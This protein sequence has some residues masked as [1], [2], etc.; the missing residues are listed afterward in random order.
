M[1]QISCVCC[2][3]RAD[4]AE[5]K[6]HLCKSACLVKARPKRK[7]SKRPPVFVLNHGPWKAWRFDIHGSA[8]KASFQNGKM[9]ADVRLTGFGAEPALVG[10]VAFSSSGDHVSG[11]AISLRQA[12]L[13]FRSGFPSTPVVS[14][15]AAGVVALEP[16]T[17]YLTGT[18][19]RPMR[20]FACN[21]PLTE[22]AIHAA[23]SAETAS[24]FSPDEN[25]F[26]LLVPAELREGVE[27]A[28]WS[29]I[30]AEPNPAAPSA[31]ENP[32]APGSGV[33]P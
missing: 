19:Q 32:P 22:K 4:I 27:L 29:E 21:P 1:S 26:S 18:L 3:L 20:V 24:G 30:K 6:I 14:A 8:E 17:L 9:S 7:R 12:T 15:E 25:R 11:N 10:S 31:V 16:F 2:S 23:F 13:D 5:L 33:P 28:D